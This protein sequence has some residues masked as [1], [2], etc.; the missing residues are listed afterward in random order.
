MK[1]P[2]SLI[3]CALALSVVAQEQDDPKPSP[4]SQRYNVYRHELTMP[5]YGVTKVKG[6]IKSIKRNDEENYPLS[7]QKFKSLTM[8]EKFAYTMLHGEDFAQNCDMMPQIMDEHKKIFAYFPNAFDHDLVWSERQRAYLDGNRSKV[9]GM[10]RETIGARRRVGVNLKQAILHLKAN[11]L[12]PDVI[13]VYK[14]DRKDRD[15]LTLLALLM[16]EG[17]DQAFFTSSIRKKLYGSMASYQA[18]IPVTRAAEDE[19][20]ARATAYYKSHTK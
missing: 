13:S 15:I 7:D 10:L 19:I 16:E 3:A 12:I 17:K 20:M 1:T 8:K 2:L 6:L 14:K 18:S 5:L 11:S 9:I 4:A